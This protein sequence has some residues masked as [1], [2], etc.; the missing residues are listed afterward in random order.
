MKEEI[1]DYLRKKDYYDI[2]GVNKNAE[3]SEIKRAF[4]KLALRFH[5]DKNSV[6]GC[7]LLMV[8]A[9]K[10]FEKVSNAY[11]TLTSAEKRER[12]DRFGP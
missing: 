2:L 10:V 11:S 6:E 1:A 12:Y 7:Y 8:G 5:P 9:K 4:K 3:E